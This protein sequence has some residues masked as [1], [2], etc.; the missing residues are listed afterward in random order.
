MRQFSSK[1][2]FNEASQ[3]CFTNIIHACTG[4]P[5]GPIWVRN[6]D[7]CRAREP[8]DVPRAR[9]GS[10][11]LAARAGSE[12]LAARAGSEV[13]AARAGSEA[14]VARAR[15]PGQRYLRYARARRVRGTCRAREFCTSS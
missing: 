13:L 4:F 14:L 10:E 3:S 6:S 15:A 2:R 1:P 9:A 12:A 11:A 5:P 7:P 8:D